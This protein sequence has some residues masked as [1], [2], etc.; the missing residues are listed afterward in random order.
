MTSRFKQA[1]NERLKTVLAEMKEGEFV[2]L[3]AI[4]PS[5]FDSIFLGNALEIAPGQSLM[6]YMRLNRFKSLLTNGAIYMR[7]LDLFELDP[8]E[9]RFPAA[10]A[11]QQYSL[12]QGLA[13]QLGFPSDSL[14]GHRNFIEGSMRKLTYVHCWFGWDNEDQEMWDE[15]GDHGCGV[16][17]RTTARRLHEALGRLHDFSA[18]LCGVTYSGDE[19]PV[20]EIISFL[21]ACRKRPQFSHEREIRLIGQLGEKTWKASYTEDGLTT[22]DHQVVGVNFERL[23]E[24]IY[25]GPNV[26]DAVFQEV[27]SLGNKAAGCRVVHRSGVS[28]F[29]PS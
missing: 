15:Y 6:H 14:K 18:N 13:E 27:E 23:F 17:V 10:N 9:G 7:R 29:Q 12:T 25:V 26:S 16:C 4:E 22:P 20:A 19:H 21:A 1:M 11:S 24:R 8:H 2:A 3:S 5:P 28:P